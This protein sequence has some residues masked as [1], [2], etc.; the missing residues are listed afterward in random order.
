MMPEGP[1][2]LYDGECGLCQRSVR[3][4]LRH[5][6]GA[7]LRFAALGSETGQRLLRERGVARET[8]AM[9]LVEPEATHVGAEAALALCAYLRWP[10]RGLRGFGVLPA[11]LR[12]RLYAA[13]AARRHRWFGRTERC[14][15]PAPGQ[16]ERFLS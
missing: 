12:A 3:F 13:V 6:R 2:V 16:A 7:E 1:V 9:V 11:G 14:A 15:L 4:L 10:W 5:E 8:D